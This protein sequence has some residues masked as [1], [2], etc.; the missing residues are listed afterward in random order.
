MKIFR[1]DGD[2]MEPL[3]REGDYVAVDTT[4]RSIREGIYAVR[5]AGSIEIRRLQ[6][7]PAGSVLLKCDNPLYSAEEVDASLLSK[8]GAIVGRVV[9][10]EKRID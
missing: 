8:G 9:F 2:A 7:L 3:F 1:V 6:L 10:A 5:L 4:Q